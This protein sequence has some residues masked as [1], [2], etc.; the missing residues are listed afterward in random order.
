MVEPAGNHDDTNV[1]ALGCL[2]F[3][4]LSRQGRYRNTGRGNGN[5]AAEGNALLR[6]RGTERSSQ[7]DNRNCERDSLHAHFPLI[8]AGSGTG[9]L[10]ITMPNALN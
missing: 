2:I 1:L 8:G 10:A 4:R 9:S 5:V 3:N 6:D 7:T